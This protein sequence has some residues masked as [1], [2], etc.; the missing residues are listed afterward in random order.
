M[1]VSGCTLEPIFLRNDT[2]FAC[3]ETT[4]CTAGFVCHEG[5]CSAESAVA[6]AGFD[7]GIDC[8]VTDSCM[9]SKRDAGFD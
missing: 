8:R 4:Q 9:M 3:S 2:A 5:V 1:L 7:A 6:D